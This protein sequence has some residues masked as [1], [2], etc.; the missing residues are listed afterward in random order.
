MRVLLGMIVGAALTVLGVYIADRGADGVT[1]K[2]I[3]NWDVASQKLEELTVGLQ[4]AWS[5]FTREMTGPT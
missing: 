4:R 5:D 1:R 3:V 2:P